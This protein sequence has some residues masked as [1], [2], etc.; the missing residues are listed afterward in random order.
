[1]TNIIKTGVSQLKHQCNRTVCLWPSLFT[2]EY[3][4]YYKSA[5]VLTCAYWNLTFLFSFPEHSLRRTNVSSNRTQQPDSKVTEERSMKWWVSSDHF[6]FLQLLNCK[7]L[8]LNF[9]GW[10][11]AR[12]ENSRKTSVQEMSP[13]T[14]DTEVKDLSHC[15]APWRITN[16]LL[17]Y[18]IHYC[19]KILR[20][21]SFLFLLV[22]P[23]YA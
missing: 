22:T 19:E 18:A 2:R 6:G 1:M 4:N 13:E 23:I 12:R 21:H 3:Y 11:D 17:E 8:L 9:S 15:R 10:R 5:V 7:L 16:L 14:V 20:H